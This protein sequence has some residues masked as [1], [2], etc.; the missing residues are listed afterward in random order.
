MRAETA[1][2]AASEPTGLDSGLAARQL[3]YFKAQ[4]E[5]WFDA[6]RRLGAWEDQHLLDAPGP[7]RLVEH[8]RLLDELEHVGGWLGR[9]TQHS[10]YPD[11]ST[12]ELVAMTVQDLKDRRAL[13]HG[14][15]SRDQREALLR[16]I[17]DES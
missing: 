2:V 3:R 17:F 16:E 4:I 12:A 6:C 11:R 5:D 13:W 14:Q 10:D 7:E 15:M 1:T 9:V 8:T